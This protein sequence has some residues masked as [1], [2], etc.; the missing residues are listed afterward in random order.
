V[1]FGAECGLPWY[2]CPNSTSTENN[3][4]KEATRHVEA[5]GRSRPIPRKEARFVL[6]IAA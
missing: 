6:G 2:I 4:A 1:V 5:V 3:I